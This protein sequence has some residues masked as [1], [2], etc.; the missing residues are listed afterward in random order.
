MLWQIWS[1]HISAHLLLNQC[2]N[3]SI[4]KNKMGWRMCLILCVL[5]IRNDEA[6]FVSVVFWLM[7]KAIHPSINAY[8]LYHSKGYS[9][10]SLEEPCVFMI[11]LIWSLLTAHDNSWG[12]EHKS[13]SKLR[14]LLYGSTFPSPAE[15]A[16]IHLSISLSLLPSL[17][18]KIYF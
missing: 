14:T 7:N 17:V 18:N 2:C 8:I 3:R 4:F 12:C 5:F 16:P 10:H 1:G 13:T 11:L 9:R 15:P 6:K